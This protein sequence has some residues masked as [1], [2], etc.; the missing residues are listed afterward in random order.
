M[1]AA[2]KTTMLQTFQG[3]PILPL[4]DEYIYV[5]NEIVIRMNILWQRVTSNSVSVVTEC[6]FNDNIVIQSNSMTM[7]ARIVIECW[8]NDNIC[9]TVLKTLRLMTSHF[10]SQPFQFRFWKS[11]CK[12]VVNVYLWV[13][14]EHNLI[15]SFHEVRRVIGTQRLTEVSKNSLV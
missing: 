14:G 7:H 9:L 1:A 2:H 4:S 10:H 12:V 6:F 8:S 3:Q 15:I 5:D 13:N 11:V